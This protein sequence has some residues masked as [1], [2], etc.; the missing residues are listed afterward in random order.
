MDENFAFLKTAGWT[1]A[2][3]LNGYSFQT[4]IFS[5]TLSHCIRFS[6]LT[7]VDAWLVVS[8]AVRFVNLF[9]S[10]LK[11]SKNFSALPRVLLK[12]E[13]A[14]LRLNN[15]EWLFGE[16][17]CQLLLCLLIPHHD[18]RPRFSLC[19]DN[20]EWRIWFHCDFVWE[21][22]L[23]AH[24][25]IELL[26]FFSTWKINK[27]NAWECKVNVSGSHFWWNRFNKYSYHL[28]WVRLSH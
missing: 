10:S 22:W 26:F 25:I 13:G 27:I 16:M 11:S 24:Y 28:I 6:R 9:L 18:N 19:E 1:S 15:V 3:R 17:H 8:S 7:H 2:R 20:F 5:P 14:T 21:A 12:D 4:H 23:S